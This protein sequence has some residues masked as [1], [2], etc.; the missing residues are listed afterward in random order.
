MDGWLHACMHARML[1]AFLLAQ[2]QDQ[3]LNGFLTRFFAISNKEITYLI[4]LVISCQ[5]FGFLYY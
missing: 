1:Y 2:L 4:P 3:L 5:Y